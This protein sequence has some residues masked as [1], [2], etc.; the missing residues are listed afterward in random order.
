MSDQRDTNPDPRNPYEF[1]LG[2]LNEIKALCTATNRW[3]AVTMFAS[4]CA[5]VLGACAFAR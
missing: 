2:E 3:Q 5:F 4:V 1:I